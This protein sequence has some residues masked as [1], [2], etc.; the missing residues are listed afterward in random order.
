MTMNTREA[1]EKVIR[2]LHSIEDWDDYKT[3][4][5]DEWDR[6]ARYSYERFKK[7]LPDADGDGF[8][9]TTSA[10]YAVNDIGT[11]IERMTEAYTRN[12]GALF[13]KLRK[14]LDDAQKDTRVR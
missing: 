10:M 13:I 6:S 2:G 11:L 14:R 12:D 8:R 5:V 3:K 9:L 7:A 1:W 4:L